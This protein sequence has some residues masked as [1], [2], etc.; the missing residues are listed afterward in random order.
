MAQEK[1]REE[2]EGKEKVRVEEWRDKERKD[3]DWESQ[4]GELLMGATNE[5][6]TAGR[7]ESED[8]RKRCG[9]GEEGKGRRE[10]RME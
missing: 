9:K 7:R 6:G 8:N 2:R 3:E 4:R 1:R 10:G 5:K